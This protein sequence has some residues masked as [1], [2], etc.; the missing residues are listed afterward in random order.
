MRPKLGFERQFEVIRWGWNIQ[1]DNHSHQQCIVYLKIAK[2]IDLKSSDLKSSHHKKKKCITMWGDGWQ[3]HLLPSIYQSMY[4]LSI[5]PPIKSYIVYLKLMH[6]C[7]LNH[8]S[9]VWLF[10]TLWTIALQALNP[11][12]ALLGWFFT[13]EPPGKPHLKLTWYVNYISIQLEK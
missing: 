13:V 9:R 3:S 12:P 5:Y 6:T 2:R 10:A 8:F 1:H 4:H 11:C 7:T